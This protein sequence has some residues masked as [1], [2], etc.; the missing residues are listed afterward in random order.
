LPANQ[1]FLRQITTDGAKWSIISQLK[2]GMN[3]NPS[4]INTIRLGVYDARMQF[5]A[6]TD[7]IEIY[8]TNDYIATG[9]LREPLYLA[10]ATVYYLALWNQNFI[11]AGFIAGGVRF[12][13]MIDCFVY[14]C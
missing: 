9:F 11:Y 1:I 2:F 12:N 10:P 13:T 5:L 6:G 7:D 4:T 3:V 14:D 8:N